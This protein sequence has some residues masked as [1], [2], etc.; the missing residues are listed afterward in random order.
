ML[1]FKDDREAAK[2]LPLLATANVTDFSPVTGLLIIEPSMASKWACCGGLGVR[3]RVDASSRESP[4]WNVQPNPVG[5]MA[6]GGQ[7]SLHQ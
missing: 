3:K 7:M 2:A 6:E 1:C 4:G 5:L